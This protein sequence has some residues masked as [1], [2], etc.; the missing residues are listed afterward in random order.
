MRVAREIRRRIIAREYIVGERLP[1]ERILA[2]SLGVSRPTAREAIIVLEID[3][4]VEVRSG[5]GAYVLSAEPKGSD[6]IEE[7]SD[8]FEILEARRA[9]EPEACALAARR[10]TEE[11]VTQ[12]G[13]LLTAMADGSSSIED[14][15]IEA[16]YRFHMTIARASANG[17]L[18]SAINK[19]WQ[20][21][22]LAPQFLQWQKPFYNR[23][24]V[25]RNL[26]HRDIYNALAHRDEA[27]A[28][29]VMYHHINRV[30]SD[31]LDLTNEWEVEQARDRSMKIRQ[32]FA[33][34][35]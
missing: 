13:S 6:R 20:S 27:T 23:S 2:E 24:A 19:L 14:Y 21:Q 26:E 16:E 1:P 10:S 4:M 31:L 15:G 11:A 22:I 35:S 33:M 30:F 5:S 3:G 32:R 7:A 18:C 9:I 34:D 29:A 28:R 12:L 17:A 25:V 8:L